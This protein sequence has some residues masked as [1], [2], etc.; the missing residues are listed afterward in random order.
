MSASLFRKSKSLFRDDELRAIRETYEALT[1][2]FEANATSGAAVRPI[3]SPTKRY[4]IAM[5][6][7]SGSSVLSAALTKTGVLG[8]P[9]ERFNYRSG[10]LL[11]WAKQWGVRDVA[12]LI[13]QVMY[14]AATPNGVAGVKGG[15]HQL[16]PYL[17]TE[18]WRA[19]Y[20]N[21][22]YIYL[23]REDVLRQAISRYK[24][25]QTE[26]WHFRGE[27]SE[28]A[29]RALREVPYDFDAIQKQVDYL[30]R[31]MESFERLFAWLGIRPY[32]ISYE[33]IVADMPGVVAEIARRLDVPLEREV[34]LEDAG[35]EKLADDHTEE[36]VSRFRADA[37][38]RLTET[39]YQGAG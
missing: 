10:Q 13:D 33:Q 20:S 12:G 5:T 15:L 37:G 36:L 3:Q 14:A 18:H 1:P 35:M 38:G 11:H 25:M 8:K 27:R 23:T 32:R 31:A 19:E 28:K 39:P 16:L 26:T 17:V 22:V 9:G 2:I 24:G 34:G 21:D 30:T 4:V 29:V 6:P 7:R